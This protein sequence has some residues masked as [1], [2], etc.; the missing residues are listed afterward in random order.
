[1]KMNSSKNSQLESQNADEEYFVCHCFSV[2]EEAI[3][4]KIHE[5]ADTVE[6]V[7]ES[8]SASSGCGSCVDIVLN[9]LN[10]NQTFQKTGKDPGLDPMS[11]GYF[12]NSK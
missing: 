11:C 12:G 3:T 6:K 8:C 5:G 1:M 7:R 9:L 2:S 4:K 10:E